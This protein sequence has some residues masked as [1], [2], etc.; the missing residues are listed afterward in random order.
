MEPIDEASST[1]PTAQLLPLPINDGLGR[2]QP[3]LLPGDEVVLQPAAAEMEGA[4]L[5][6]HDGVQVGD[7]RN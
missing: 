2:L 1:G 7:E 6:F 3:A 4:L 5:L